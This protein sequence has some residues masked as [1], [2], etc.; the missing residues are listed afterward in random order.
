MTAVTTVAPSEGGNRSHLR[1]V[2][3]VI[4]PRRGRG[5][6]SVVLASLSLICAIGLIATSAWLISRA[7]QQPP[8]LYLSV[9]VV[10]VRAFG[11]GRGVFRYWERLVSH[12]AACVEGGVGMHF[13]GWLTTSTRAPS[14]GC[15]RCCPP[16]QPSSWAHV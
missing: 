12:S 8:I 7:W 9:A 16:P 4:K 2:W 1:Q 13:A 6:L 10:S 3:A 14:L 11:L 5:L 15:E